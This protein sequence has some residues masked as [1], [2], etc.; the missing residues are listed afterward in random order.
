M[1]YSLKHFLKEVE[2]VSQMKNL[3]QIEFKQLVFHLS[4][5]L[6]KLK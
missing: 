4:K 6:R 5:T 1:D 2:R 3:I